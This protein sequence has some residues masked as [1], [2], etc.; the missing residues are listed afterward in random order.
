MSP[1]S[2]ARVVILMSI[3]IEHEP[4][5]RGQDSVEQLRAVREQ[6]HSSHLRSMR[7]TIVLARVW[8]PQLPGS[9]LMAV[10]LLSPTLMLPEVFM[11]GSVQSS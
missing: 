7:R 4:W 5:G 10:P 9:P 1:H 3:T 2:Q 11:S 8:M 6:T